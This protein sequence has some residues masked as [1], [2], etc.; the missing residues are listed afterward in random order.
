[1]NHKFTDVNTMLVYDQRQGGVVELQF[2]SRYRHHLYKWVPNERSI[3][4]LNDDH[5]RAD[6]L[7]QG[8]NRIYFNTF[9]SSNK[10]IMSF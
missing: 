10:F 4:A 9:L 5:F 3:S 1:M 7:T 2:Y 8:S 6:R